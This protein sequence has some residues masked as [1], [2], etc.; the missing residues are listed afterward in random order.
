MGRIRE[1]LILTDEFS[2]SFARFLQMGEQAARGMEM[3]GQSNEEFTRSAAGMSSEFVRS[4]AGMSREIERMRELMKSLPKENPVEW[5]AFEAPEVIKSTGMQRTFQEVYRIND[6]LEKMASMQYQITQQANETQILSPEASYDVQMV[7]NRLADMQETIRQIESNPL[8]LGTAEANGALEQMHFRLRETMTLQDELNRAMQGNDMGA[9]NEAYLR[10]SQNISNTERYLR[11]SFSH[12]PPVEIPV[13]W[14]MEAIPIF[15]NSGIER[16][17]QEITAANSMLNQLSAAQNAIAAKAADSRVFP[18]GAV[19][20]LT[21]MSGRIDA[22][23]QQIQAMEANPL[24]MGA[25]AAN[26][27]IE[28]LREQL[29]QA[30]HEQNRLTQAIEDMDVN[31]ASEAYQRLQRMVGNTERYIRDNMTEQQEFNREISRGAEGA[32]KLARMIKNAVTAY[33]SIHTLK[34]IIGLSD[35]M[36]STTARLSLMLTEMNDELQ[37]T[38]S[39]QEMIYRSAQRARGSYQATA[40]AV[41]KLGLMAGNAFSNSAEVVAFMEQ[42]NK[43]F[44]IAGTESAGIQAAMLQ[45]TQAM[46]SG[47][48]RGEEYNSILEQAPNIIQNIAK[49]IEGNEEVLKGVAKAMKMDIDDLA[50]NVQK[51]LKDIASEGIISAEL[52]KAAMFAA[53]EDTDEKFERMPETF[54]QVWEDFQNRAVS[55]LQPMLSVLNDVAN[56]AVIGDTLDGIAERMEALAGSEELQA[57]INGLING[58]DLFGRVAFAVFDLSAAAAGFAADNWSDIA[59]ILWGVA[60]AAGAVAIAKGIMAAA[61]WAAAA[62]NDA[63]VVSLLS[64]PLTWLAV[65]V[66]LI[67]TWIYRWI[68]SV[69]GITVAWLM[70]K[71]VVLTV[72]D[73]LQIGVMTGVFAVQNWMGSMYLKIATVGVNIANAIG[74]MKVKVLTHIENMVNGAI[75]LLNDFIG[76]LNKIP[77]VA[78]SAIDK[79]TFSASAAASNEAAKNARASELSAL[80]AANAENEQARKQQLEEMRRSA[81]RDRMERLSGIASAQAGSDNAGNKASESSASEFADLM[82]NSS[83]PSLGGKAADIGKVGSVGNVKNVEGEISLADEDAKLYRDLAERRY[84]NQIEL[85]TL[86][87]AITVNLPEGAAGNMKPEDVANVLKKL[88][89]EQMGANTA[90]SHG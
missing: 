49:Y 64:N 41:A 27:R 63:L 11:D 7:E 50:G 68:Q 85:K 71:N 82:S 86:A 56:S 2:A 34:S 70:A 37:T 58:M 73:E 55:S 65:G 83:T 84:M 3:L 57:F 77:G 81:D 78:I 53:A 66:A 60:A 43:Q 10:L 69:G 67:V 5:K 87:P 72:W 29:S 23:R 76:M 32:D 22:I 9:I 4:A 44:R 31:A 48:L 21:A 18:P 17:Q 39:L 35:Q 80:S 6:V 16:F 30:A 13:I 89:I 54:S 45:L 20:D 79:V 8:N 61:D 14:Q 33:L 52:I 42:I 59:P 12:I 24:D 28:Q 75:S 25:E 90:I 15:T 38:E 46:A 36:V 47:V 1:E 88:L 26:N 19:N 40:E 62:A 74:D 51:N